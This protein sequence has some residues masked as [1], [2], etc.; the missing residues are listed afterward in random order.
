[1]ACHIPL[2]KAFVEGYNFASDFTSI[3][4]KLWAF[5]IVEVLILGIPGLPLGSP[6]IK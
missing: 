6:M 3:G 2:E 1:V 4:T 5:K